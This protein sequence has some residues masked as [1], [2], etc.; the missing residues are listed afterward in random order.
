[1]K[2]DFNKIINI[3]SINDL[4]KFDIDKQLYNNNYLFHYLI[5]FDK[6]DILKL[7]TFPIYKENDEGLN[8][9]FLA[10]KNN[11]IKILK[12]LIK[13]Y[14]EYI[15]N[16][17][18]ENNL[19]IN[20]LEIDNIVKI[21]NNKLDWNLIISSEILD[22]LLLK[23][24][25]KELNKLI[26]VYKIKNYYLGSII[27][28]LKL[29][30]DEKIKILNMYPKEINIYNNEHINLIYPAIYIKDI[31]I[32]K[33]LIKKNINL[34]YYANNNYL[35]S[36]LKYALFNNMLNAYEL[37]WN[38]IKENYNYDM[39][40]INLENI[41]HF[42]FKKKS[43]QKKEEKNSFI[44]NETSLDILYNCPSKVWNQ[45]NIN[46]V[47]PFELLTR[48]DYKKYNYLLKNKEI[49]INLLTKKPSDEWFTFLN[50]LSLYKEDID[51][52]IENYP[53]MHY[54][55]FQAYHIDVCLYA[56]YLKNKYKNLY[57]PTIKDNKIDTFIDFENIMIDLQV[58]EQKLLFP[59][60]IYYESEDKY[61]IHLELNNLINSQR[62]KNIYDFAFCYISIR[63]DNMLHANLLIY[64][65]NN[66]TIER[67]EPYGT[68]MIDN[69]NIDSILEE[70][71]TWN[72]GF[73]YLKPC[74]YIKKSGFQYVSD[75]IN[76]LNQK[77]G[78]FGGY[79]LAWCTWYLEHRILNKNIKSELLIIKLFNIL[80]INNNSFMEYIRNYAN[81]LNNERIKLLK[82]IGIKDNIITNINY[83]NDIYNKIYNYIINKF[84]L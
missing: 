44:F 24:K 14:S 76:P 11:N 75:E 4:N 55:L 33:Y 42:I 51:I 45:K 43:S 10:A 66:F 13:T 29:I 28:N 23:L 17:D 41:A 47:T 56:L 60:L 26:K 79:C 18:N 30:S 9:I 78:D 67:F 46:K 83:T 70:E 8:G 74:N 27:L 82:E 73:K 68:L 38:K 61:Y 39:I 54:N 81:K 31:K 69:N 15:Y 53:Y 7:K 58:S 3:K 1:M 48:Y 84:N 77:N 62:R 50:K 21:L 64:D 65:F 20:Y 16:R 59:W 71:L 5:I 12:Y 49:N 72:T 34:D 19:F 80:N 2:I 22:I 25:F 6:L 36:P 35:S 57:C 37:I 63:F 40:D 32:V 52:K